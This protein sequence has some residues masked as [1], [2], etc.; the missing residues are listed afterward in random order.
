MVP[1]HHMNIRTMYCP[2]L[3]SCQVQ[4]WLTMTC[5]FFTIEDEQRTLKVLIFWE[6][7]AS[8]SKKV[9]EAITARGKIGPKKIQPDP[10]QARGY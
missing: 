8:E 1:N 10:T 6:W 5:N 4:F 2:A 7:S 9:E 3:I